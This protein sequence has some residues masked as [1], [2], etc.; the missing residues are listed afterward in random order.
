MITSTGNLVLDPDA[1]IDLHLH[2]TFSD[3][4][5]APEQLMDYLVIEKFGLVTIADHDRVDTVD[6]IIVIFNIP[7]YANW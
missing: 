2:T 5:W 3:G 1:A 4:V 7:F 6:V